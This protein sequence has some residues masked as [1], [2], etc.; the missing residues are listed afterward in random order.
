MA[1]LCCIAQVIDSAV[2]RLILAEPAGA[3]SRHIELST[4][5]AAKAST[6]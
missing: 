2:V 4:C 6:K 5:L 1:S 3:G